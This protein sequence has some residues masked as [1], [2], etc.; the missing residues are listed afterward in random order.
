MC[1]TFSGQRTIDTVLDIEKE[2]E[3]VLS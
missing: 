2:T 3:D 1:L